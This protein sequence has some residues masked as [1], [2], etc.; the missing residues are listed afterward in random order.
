MITP[1]SSGTVAA[2][3]LPD[4]TQWITFTPSADWQLGATYT[5]VLRSGD[6]AGATEIARWSFAAAPQPAVIGRFPGEGQTLPPGQDVRLIFNTPVDGAALEAALRLT[7]P[8]GVLRVSAS[9]VEARISAEMRA[10]TVYTLTL[11]ASLTDRNGVPLGREYQ[12]RFVTASTGS[13]LKL[14]DAPVHIIQFAPGQPANLRV[15][16]TNLSALNI[17]LYSLDEATT[18]RALA[19]EERD[20]HDFQPERYAQP[21]LRRGWCRS[22]IR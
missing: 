16:R 9:D 11:P 1:T 21:L 8:A 3:L 5:A 7:P 15:Q 2:V 17:E 14:P 4:A 20:W 10:S 13:A 6:G 18:V 22:A 12:I 19:F